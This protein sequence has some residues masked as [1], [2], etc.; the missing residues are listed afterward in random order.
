MRSR[1]TMS[2][3]AA[4]RATSTARSTSTATA[5]AG[6]RLVGA[7]GLTHPPIAVSPQRSNGWR[8]L[9]VRVG[10]GGAKADDVELAFDGKTYPANPTAAAKGITPGNGD[11]E[12]VIAPFASF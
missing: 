8:N 4:R 2:R 6:Y 5:G 10:G 1:R 3:K 9:V 12:V 7:I 11:S